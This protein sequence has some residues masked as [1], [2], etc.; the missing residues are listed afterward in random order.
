V[1]Y[2]TSIVPRSEK[3]RERIR[4]AE[5]EYPWQESDVEAMKTVKW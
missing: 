1:P 2:R 3:H 5:K 4:Q